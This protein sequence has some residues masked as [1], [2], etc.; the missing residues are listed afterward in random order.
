MRKLSLLLF[1]LLLILPTLSGCAAAPTP[2]SI[3][4]MVSGSKAEYEAY[5]TLVDSFQSANPDYT[6]E[7]R[8]MPDDADYLRRLAE[9]LPR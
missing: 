8:Y 9:A 1:V 7:L 4:F 2:H 3:S 6:V 5:Q